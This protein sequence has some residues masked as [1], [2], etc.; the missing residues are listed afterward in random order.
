GLLHRVYLF[1][2]FHD[3][4]AGAPVAKARKAGVPDDAQEPGAAV[5]PSEAV[6]VP[7]RA[8]KG[9]LDG[10]LRILSVA[11]EVSRQIVRGV[12]VRQDA[13]MEAVQL[14]RREATLW[15]GRVR[16]AHA[17]SFIQGDSWS[18]RFIPGMP[19][20][21]APGIT[22]TS[23]GSGSVERSTVRYPDLEVVH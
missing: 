1:V 15:A 3:L 13:L 16:S 4:T 21:S 19:G 23:N 20:L 2:E 9:V 10:V 17:R 22:S 12:Q 8:K 6:E 11:K 7:D 5:R 14:S 18:T